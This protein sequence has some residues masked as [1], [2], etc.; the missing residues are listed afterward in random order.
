MAIVLIGTLDTKGQ[1]LAFV[2]HLLH[3]RG[4]VTLIIDAGS[5]GPPSIV[6]DIGR[7]EVFR[8]SGASPGG[9]KD[10]GEA[11]SR[12]AE[13]VALVVAELHRLGQVDGIFGLGG[14][15]GTVIGTAAMRALPFGLPKVMVSTLASGQ[16]R[17]YVGG[18]DIL[19]LYPVADL[20]GLNR[21][22]RSA[23]TNAANALVGMVR[24]PRPAAEAGAA[25]RPLVAA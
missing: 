4:L 16:T 5:Q 11:V 13:G 22:T 2:R 18:S 20:A 21:L 12:A 19:M 15:A 10:R 25:D 23:L 8:R 14:S 24:G 3:A 9:L 7:D 17:P 6:P 1:E